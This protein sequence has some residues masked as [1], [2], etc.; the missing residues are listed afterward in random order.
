MG[1]QSRHTTGVAAGDRK[2][3]RVFGRKKRHAEDAPA[4]Q[5][6]EHEPEE[7]EVEGA[8][9]VPAAAETTPET[10]ETASSDLD[11]QPKELVEGRE[12]DGPFDFSEISGTRPFIDFGA[13]LLPPTPGLTIRVEVEERT[14]RPVA[15][16]LEHEGT[17][18]QLQAFAA[19]RSAGLWAEVRAQLAAQLAAQHAEHREFQGE[20]GWELHAAL[21]TPEGPRTV[22]FLGVDGPRWF[23]RGVVTGAALED[24]DGARRVNALFRSLIVHRGGEPR[25][26]REL[27]P[28]TLPQPAAQV[29][30]ADA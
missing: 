20:L 18:L 9:A 24:K 22:R 27:L 14:K 4:E 13:V 1:R 28:L 5:A 29:R 21:P 2:E 15:I 26:P 23:L 16:T 30:P 6:V 10:S 8:E 3:S 19:P 17:Q 11:F 25:A 12:Q 7:T